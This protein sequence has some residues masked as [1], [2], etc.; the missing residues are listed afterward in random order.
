MLRL[1]VFTKLDNRERKSP[2]AEEATTTKLLTDL[3]GY[4]SW[5]KFEGA[6]KCTDYSLM[7]PKVDVKVD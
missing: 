5:E 4:Y 1:F 7:F 3:E 6:A 2:I